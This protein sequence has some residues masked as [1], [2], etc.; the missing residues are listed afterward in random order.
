M[1]NDKKKLLEPY[2]ELARKL[3]K[4]PSR[5]EY[6]K[7]IGSPHQI[8][9]EFDGYSNVKTAALAQSP[10]LETMTM[11]AKLAAQDISAYRMD[12]E[13]KDRKTDNKSLV[14][15][16]S[17][18]EYIS[19][20]AEK[21]FSG[22]VKANAYK[23]KDVKTQR[24]VNL[25]LSD[26]HIGA[27][28]SG[29]ETGASSFGKKEESRRL[30]QV[31]QEACNYKL[32]HRDETV[33]HL[34]LL[35][36]I[37]QGDLKHDPRDGAELAEQFCRGVHLILQ[38]VAVL[39]EH[40]KEIKVFCATGNHDRYVGRHPGRAI[41]SKYDSFATMLYY[42]VMKA[43]DQLE[44]VTFNIPKTPY[45]VSQ[46]FDKKIF[47][48]HGDTGLKTGSVGNAI[49]VSN[50]EKGMNKINA[51][52]KDSNEYAAFICGHLHTGTVVFLS[53]G[54]TLIVNGGL[55]PVDSFGVSMGMHE[56]NSGQM[57]FESIPG[58]AVGDIRYIRVNEQTDKNVSL[59][60]IL[61]PWKGFED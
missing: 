7:F 45:V 58:L 15:S 38:S 47:L 50:I 22:K 36:D 44:N 6:Q 12:L 52:L 11:P 5:N 1:A 18:L 41:H 2:I 23:A 8:S 33:L 16:V 56:T 51:S 27:D 43:C 31:V 39:S 24:I 60:K 21:T 17:T 10:D 35:G 49:S 59:D 9:K 25:V 4:L 26:L 13:A 28:I 57:L 20:F 19:R 40:F 61:K 46:N 54:A 3:N 53:N 37:I 14:T 42:S 29:D 34:H 55:P 48:W 30:A 32:Q